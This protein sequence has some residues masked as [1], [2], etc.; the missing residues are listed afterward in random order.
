[1]K[2]LAEQAKVLKK[3]SELCRQF[4]AESRQLKAKIAELESKLDEQVKEA[5]VHDL[6]LKLTLDD[7]TVK[8]ITEKMAHLRSRNLDVVEEAIELGMT[9]KIAS[10]GDVHDS[11][12]D[13]TDLSPE[14]QFL[15]ALQG[16]R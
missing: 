5:K 12:E 16:S 15:R 11:D 13:V 1:M 14:V 9:D 8:D 3:A 6:A 7:D 4:D 10:L 2:K